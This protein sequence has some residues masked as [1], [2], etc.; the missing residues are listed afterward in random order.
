MAGRE[1]VLRVEKG[2]RGHRSRGEEARRRGAVAVTA[3]RISRRGIS[4]SGRRSC[5]EEAR[6]SGAVKPRG[7]AAGIS[8]HG[9]GRRVLRRR[10]REEGVAAAG[11]H[12]TAEGGGC[13]GGSRLQRGGEMDRRG[14]EEHAVICGREEREGERRGA[15]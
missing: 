5:G 2:R 1:P 7:V 3:R 9:G 13:C 14:W 10:Q 4:W 15:W 8:P 11:S 12:R 6:R